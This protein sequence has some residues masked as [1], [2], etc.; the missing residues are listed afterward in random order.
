MPPPK[1]GT[2]NPPE[3]TKP[4]PE[5]PIVESIG[6]QKT[7]KGHVVVLVKT[8]GDKVLDR[9]LLS[10]PGSQVLAMEWFKIQTVRRIFS[11]AATKGVSA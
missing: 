8:Q 7:A 10:E 4:E 3:G 5:L 6:L 11:T 1:I 9:E 2:K